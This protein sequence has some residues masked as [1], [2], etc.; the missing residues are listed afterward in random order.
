MV[1]DHVEEGH[2]EAVDEALE[3]VPL[4]VEHG[5]V[6]GVALDQVAHAHHELG[7]HPV[8]LAHR[9]FEHAVAVLAGAIGHDRE[10]EL[11]GIGE[12]GE[13]GPRHLLGRA[14]HLGVE[15]RRGVA[16]EERAAAHGEAEPE[17]EREGGAGRC[18]RFSWRAH[19]GDAA[20]CRAPP[21]AA[22]LTRRSAQRRAAGCHAAR[23]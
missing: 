2:L 23:T 11:V 5:A 15:A 8:E 17:G 16:G 21:A 13:A 6:V 7:A 18:H 22:T 4:A 1:A 10:A 12:G 3:L 14:L 19:A 9:A 20:G